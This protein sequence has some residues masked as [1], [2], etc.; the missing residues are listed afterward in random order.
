M[1]V[2]PSLVTMNVEDSPV[3]DL[4]GWTLQPVLRELYFRG[5]SITRVE[6][7]AGQTSLRTL[8]F[9]SSVGIVDVSTLQLLVDAGC[10]VDIL[11]R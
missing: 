10:T 9:D 4:G 11:P 2:Q 8:M 5:H 6:P 7:L 1:R 3:A